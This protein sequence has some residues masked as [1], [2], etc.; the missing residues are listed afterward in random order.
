MN[1]MKLLSVGLGVIVIIVA[2]VAVFGSSFKKLSAPTENESTGSFVAKE[3]TENESL[4]SKDSPSNTNQPTTSPTPNTT[5]TTTV[6]GYTL[7]EV[8]AHDSAASCWSAVNG[9]VYDLTGW[10]NQHPGGKAAILMICGKDG[11]PLFNMQHGGEGRPASILAKYRL[12][13]LRS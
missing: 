1:K 6:S 4:P 9:S 10:V 8:A 3:P 12:S 11:S 2:F 5:A 13:A 7:A